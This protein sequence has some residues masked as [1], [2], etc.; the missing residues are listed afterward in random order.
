MYSDGYVMGMQIALYIPP[1]PPALSIL[2]PF[3]TPLNTTYYI[4]AYHGYAEGTKGG[5]GALYVYDRHTNFSVIYN[6]HTMESILLK[7]EDA[8]CET[9]NMTIDLAMFP[10]GYL[11]GSLPIPIPDVIADMTNFHQHNLRQRGSKFLI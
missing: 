9:K 2:L 8:S 11:H 10:F 4:E 7:H 6:E 3:A 5:H 1:L